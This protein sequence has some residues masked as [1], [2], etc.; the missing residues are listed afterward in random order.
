M[1]MLTEVIN[2]AAR[3]KHR[4][5]LMTVRTAGL[6]RRMCTATVTDKFTVAEQQRMLTLFANHAH[7]G[8][9]LTL[10]STK[11]E[12]Q[13]AL[14]C[15]TLILFHVRHQAFTFTLLSW[16]QQVTL[17]FIRVITLFKLNTDRRTHHVQ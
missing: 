5:R 16:R 9:L 12:G 8:L 15:L 17:A 6:R 3:F 4:Q 13:Q 10:L 1:P 2:R 14:S 11:K 7:A